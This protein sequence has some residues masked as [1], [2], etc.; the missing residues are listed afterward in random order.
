MRNTRKR[1]RSKRCENAQEDVTHSY[2]K[3]TNDIYTYP[4]LQT[5]LRYSMITALPKNVSS[6]KV[7]LRIHTKYFPM[8]SQKTLVPRSYFPWIHKK[9]Y[10]QEVKFFDN[11]KEV[12]LPRS[13]HCQNNNL[14]KFNFITGKFRFNLHPRFLDSLTTSCTVYLIYIYIYI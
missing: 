13:P 11:C 12:T 6:K 10:Y 7:C 9:N 14:E 3:G 8:E 1:T 4:H 5:L 2:A